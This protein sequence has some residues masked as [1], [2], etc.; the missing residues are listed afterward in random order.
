MERGFWEAILGGLR[1]A[2]GA[3]GGEEAADMNDGYEG[4]ASLYSVLLKV[5]ER[6]NAT[7]HRVMHP[8]TSYKDWLAGSSLHLCYVQITDSLTT[9]ASPKTHGV[10]AVGSE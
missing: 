10:D 8:A 2:P 9:Q 4:G 1:D 5:C 7:W 6:L 3:A